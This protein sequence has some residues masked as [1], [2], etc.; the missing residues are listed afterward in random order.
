MM[1]EKGVPAGKIV[2]WAAKSAGL[3]GE[4]EVVDHPSEVV[5]RFHWSKVTHDDVVADPHWVFRVLV[6]LCRSKIVSPTIMWQ[7]VV[8]CVST[9]VV[10]SWSNSIHQSPSCEWIRILK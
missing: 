8:A 1:R 9:Y 7:C 4:N 10:E 6:K 2:D 5:S 3:I